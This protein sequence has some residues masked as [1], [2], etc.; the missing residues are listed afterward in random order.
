[1]QERI[2]NHVT[3]HVMYSDNELLNELVMFIISVINNTDSILYTV[4]DIHNK[5]KH[6][7]NT[8]QPL[9]IGYLTHGY[10]GNL[11]IKDNMGTVSCLVGI[12]VYM[13]VLINI[14]HC[15]SFQL[16]D[17]SIS[18]IENYIVLQEWNYISSKYH[19]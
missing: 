1:M 9:L 10:Y 3:S 19:S 14:N 4:D 13:Y 8:T 5:H 16:R 2:Q 7:T 12:Y 18:D 6:A 15:F 11:M 17:L